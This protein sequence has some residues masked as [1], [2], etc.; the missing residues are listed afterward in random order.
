MSDFQADIEQFAA[1]AVEAAS[2]MDFGPLDYSEAGL[3]TLEN[4]L[5]DLASYGDQ[6]SDANRLIL[7]Q[8]FGC[9]LLEVARRTFGGQYFWYEDREPIL[10]V[11]EPDFHVALMTWGKVD[12]RLKGEEA[13][14]ILF[15]YRGFADRVKA[16]KPGDRALY[17]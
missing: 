8:Q 12:G 1:A 16:A 4:I 15:F 2:E 14:N 7:H 13:D 5:A 6:I 9:Y 3:T 10:V 11:G 17:H